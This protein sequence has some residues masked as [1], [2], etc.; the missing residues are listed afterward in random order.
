MVASFNC[1]CCCGFIFMG[2]FSGGDEGTV[3][4]TPPLTIDR[5]L[6]RCANAN[7][8]KYDASR[9]V[10]TT[11]DGLTGLYLATNG[12][13]LGGGGPSLLLKVEEFP[14]PGGEDIRV[15]VGG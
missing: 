3:P 4:P 1:V 2:L 13:C 8:S 12:S 6:A 5:A 11:D 15:V 10:S 9:R 14:T 7:T